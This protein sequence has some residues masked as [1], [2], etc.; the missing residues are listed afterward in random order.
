MRKS[1][2]VLVSSFL[3]LAAAALLG[4][5]GGQSTTPPDATTK[6]PGEQDQKFMK[7]AAVGDAAEIQL[8]QLADAKASDPRVKHF[9]ERM[10]TDHSKADDQLKNI[11]GSQHISLPTELDPPHKNMKAALSIQSGSEFDKNY[12]RTMV[13][14]HLKTLKKFQR[15]AASSQDPSIKQFTMN[16]IPVIQSHLNAARQIESQIGIH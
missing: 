10:V 16:S 7:D 5:Q 14:E 6:A 9:G 12:M 11:A 4:Q 13:Q 3:M 1:A 15:E 8:G 2:I